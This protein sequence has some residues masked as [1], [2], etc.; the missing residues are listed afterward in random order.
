MNL[1]QN[2]LLKSLY[3]IGGALVAMIGQALLDFKPSGDATTVALWNF[4][5][6]GI[7]TGLVATGKRVIRGESY[8]K[9]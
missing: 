5:I 2:F 6:V 7:A 3:G 8:K 4:L 9:P 1:I